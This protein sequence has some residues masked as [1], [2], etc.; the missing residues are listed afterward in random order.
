MEYLQNLQSKTKWQHQK[1][2][3]QVNDVV[4]VKPDS[5]FHC[6]WPIARII[7]THPGK[8]KIVRVVTLTT[9]SGIY[10]R[11]VAKVSLLFRP[12]HDQEDAEPT[13]LP[14]A[15]CSDTPDQTR[16]MPD[17]HPRQQREDALAGNPS[18]IWRDT[19]TTKT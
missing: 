19:S 14:P 3:L 4:I 11:P 15:G 10:K 5:H 9:A 12:T 13:P 17:A 2:D 16:V 8:D 18:T 6:H 7:E 1:P